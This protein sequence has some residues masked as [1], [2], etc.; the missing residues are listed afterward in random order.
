MLMVQVK[1][2]LDDHQKMGHVRALELI[3]DLQRLGISYHF[4][5]KINQILNRIYFEYETEKKGL[6]STA[7]GFR[8][9]RQHGFKVSQGALN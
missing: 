7:L 8:L 9:L 4:Q 5:E 1:M 6:Y 2:L 3:D